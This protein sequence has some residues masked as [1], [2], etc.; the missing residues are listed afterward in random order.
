MHCEGLDNLCVVGGDAAQVVRHHIDRRSV[1]HVCINFPEPPHHSGLEDAE[2]RLHLLTDEFFLDVFEVL[3]DEGV[4]CVFSDA[5]KY[6]Q[7]LAQSLG[8][9]KKKKKANII[10][11]DTDHPHED[12]GGIRLYEGLPPQGCGHVVNETS[13]FDRFWEHGKR[14]RRFYLAVRLHR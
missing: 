8:K 1:S 10:T 3:Q 4:M 13:Y 2:S 14:V 12:F 11:L 5:Q 9:I 7:Q 6:M